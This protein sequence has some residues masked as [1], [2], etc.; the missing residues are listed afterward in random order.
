M[1]SPGLKFTVAKEDN[2]A[3][4]RVHVPLCPRSCA[5]GAQ[6]QGFTHGR[7]ALTA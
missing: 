7:C 4:L 1:I 5:A 3:L 2:L 6:T